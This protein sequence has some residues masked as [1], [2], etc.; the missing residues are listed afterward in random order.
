M[1]GHTAS[2]GEWKQQRA[3]LLGIVTAVVW[4]AQQGMPVS[5]HALP[6]LLHHDVQS[7]CCLGILNRTV[8]RLLD[9]DPQD[10]L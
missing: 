7:H 1:T 2:V 9:P 6:L 5:G 8:L 4:S 3:G 10:L